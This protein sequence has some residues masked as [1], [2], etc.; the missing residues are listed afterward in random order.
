M[1][2]LNNSRPVKPLYYSTQIVWYLFAILQTLLAFR[3]V[4][5]LTG[6][7]PEAGFTSII[8]SATQPFVAPFHAVFQT[9]T[10]EGSIFE[11]TTLLAMLVYWMIAV[12]IVKLLLLVGENVLSSEEARRVE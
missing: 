7:N 4:L 2:S 10:V 6:A 12:A 11:W 3:F 5:K 1:N 8:Y 9:S